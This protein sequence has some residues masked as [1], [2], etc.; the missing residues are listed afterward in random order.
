VSD[1]LGE[2]FEFEPSSFDQG[3]DEML[4]AN[5][6]LTGAAG[7]SES[8]QGS[9]GDQLRQWLPTVPAAE[10]I[11]KVEATADEALSQATNIT[12][13]DA[14][15][16]LT[17]KQTMLTTEARI[18]ERIEEIRSG[19]TSS[20]T[21]AID[22]ATPSQIDQSLSGQPSTPVRGDDSESYAAHVDQQIEERI[23]KLANDAPGSHG[24]QR[25]LEVSD[26]QLQQRLGTPLLNPDGTPQLKANG[27]VKATDQIDPMTGTTTDAITGAL[28]RCG[29][30]ATRFDSPSDYAHVD[31]V[32]RSR[33]DITGE[34]H[35]EASIEDILGTEGH[36]RMTGYYID[37]ARPGNYLPVNFQGGSVAATYRYDI[38]GR[39]QLYTMYPVP[40]PGIQP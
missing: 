33:A 8:V 23:D 35:Q 27:F 26:E 25:H 4:E 15:K 32:L 17:Q 20:E 9:A 22:D 11:D 13:E 29:T 31:S 19:P 3:S 5:S 18:T 38:Y 14:E 6:H 7:Q 37:P 39:P 30:L 36:T 24:P 1:G 10:T 2:G 40:T 21:G 34:G 12:R 16:L 28:H